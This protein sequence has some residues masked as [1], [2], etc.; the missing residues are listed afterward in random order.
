MSET[1]LVAPFA[2]GGPTEV[3]AVLARRLLELALAEGGDYADLFFEYRAGA[4]YLYEDER[5]KSVGRGITL[6]LG[7]RVLKG[8]ATGYAYCEELTWEAMAQAARTAAQIASSGKSPAPV[9]I[10]ALSV[11]SFYPVKVPS[12]ETLPEA[13]LEL[14]RRGD[15]AARAFDPRIVKVQVSFVEEIK[16]ILIVTADGRLARDRQ[17]L[18]RFGVHAIAESGGKRQAGSGGGG[19]RFGMEYFD[20][21]P[22]ESH[23][24]EAARVAIAMLDAVDAPAGQMEVVLG[25]GDSG[26]LLHEAVGHGLEADFN[27]KETSNYSGQIGKPVASEKCTVVDDG[28]LHHTRGAINVDDEGNLPRKNVL[29]EKGIL[30]A[31]LQ[32]EIS[33]KHYQV[34]PSGNGRRQSF[35]CN[36]LPRMTNTL[37]DAG[38]DDP[39]EIVRSVK[40]G[41]YAKRFSGG[42]VNISNGDFVFSLTE[43]Y[44]IED[45]K[46]TAPLKGVNLIGNGPDVLTRVTMVG[47]DFQ[48]S[49]GIWTCGK[50]GQ[51]VPVGVGTPTVKIAG[52]TVGGTKA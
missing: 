40:R 47:S 14:L 17:P 15:R 49:D 13:K 26:I 31:Y 39:E 16:E 35:R 21:H 3:D 12:I 1:K 10:R 27:R 48:L 29:I 22:P 2:Q 30:R 46:L 50:D 34:S 28:T 7:V 23:G 4:D 5:V 37:L 25:P 51:S 19:G 41:V 8:D 18:L 6:G 33:A 38:D 44:L 20:A 52:I 43:S 42:Q 9:D 45:G 24:R 11:P 32:D 36:P